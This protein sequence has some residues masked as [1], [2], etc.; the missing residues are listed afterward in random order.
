MP[1]V[2][3]QKYFSFILAAIFGDHREIAASL[4][5][6]RLNPFFPFTKTFDSL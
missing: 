5:S 2:A 6:S 3:R 1:T 4:R